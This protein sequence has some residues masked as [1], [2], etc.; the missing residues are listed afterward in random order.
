MRIFVTDTVIGEESQK[1]K[2]LTM[3]CVILEKISKLHHNFRSFVIGQNKS[4]TFRYPPTPAGLI[5]KRAMSTFFFE[6][7]QL[8]LSEKKVFKWPNRSFRGQGGVAGASSCYIL[9][10]SQSIAS[11]LCLEWMRMLIPDSVQISPIYDLHL[12]QSQAL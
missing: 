7:L 5:Q 4:R 2:N 12:E 1:M 11:L 9:F 6:A 8:E 3:I 10:Q